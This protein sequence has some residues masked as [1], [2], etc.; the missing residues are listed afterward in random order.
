MLHCTDCI[1]ELNNTQI[2]NAK[3]IDVLTDAGAL[4]NFPGN[5]ASL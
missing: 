3:E 2:D 4:D 1:S 5:C